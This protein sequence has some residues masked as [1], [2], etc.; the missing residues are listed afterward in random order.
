MKKP[1]KTIG[2]P[3]KRSP[4]KTRYPG[5]P[6][7]VLV[8]QVLNDFS[9]L[10]EQLGVARLRQLPKYRG[11]APVKHAHIVENYANTLAISD[12][13][14]LWHQDPDY[15]DARGMPI[16]IRMRAGNPCF[17]SLAERS[18]PDMPPARLIR[19]L[20]RL[21]AIRID[22][23]RYIHVRVRSLITYR[24]K[25]H[26]IIHTL[27]SLHGFINTLLHN[28]EI[29]PSNTEPLFQR[30]AWNSNLEFKDIPR[31]NT[32]LKR[33]GQALLESA[34][35]WMMRRSAKEKSPLIRRR[36][37]ANVSVGVY[38]SVNSHE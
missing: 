28:I 18:V 32:W 9:M 21:R 24:D 5:R 33:H 29:E 31:L 36:R 15:L 38:L 22:E 11:T 4:A 6:S 1:R 35:G 10:F 7:E 26:T 37:A 19:E 12:L 23:R 16:P 34:D 8:Q 27:N 14:T 30:V 25:R 2:K 20:K 17:R 3:K 13:L